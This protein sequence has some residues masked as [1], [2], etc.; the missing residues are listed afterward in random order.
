MRDLVR[1]IVEGYKAL[2]L[3]G[4]SEGYV[5]FRG[6]EPDT[7]QQVWIKILPRL[8]VQ[9][10]EMAQRVAALSQAIRQLNHPNIVAVRKLGEQ[11]GLPYLIT[12]ALEAAQPLAA[13]LNQPWAVDEAADLVM[14]VGRALE[15]AHAKG[16]LHGSLSPENI[17][18][19]NSGRVQVTDFGLAELQELTG[20]RARGTVSPYLAPERQAGAKGDGRSDVY[21]LAAILYGMLAQRNPQIVRGEVLPPGRFNPE[22]PAAM[23]AVVVKALAPNATD[24]YPDVKSFLAAFGAVTLAPMIKQAPP[25]PPGT[26]CLKCGAKGQSGRFCRACGARLGSVPARAPVLSKKSILD[27]PIQQTRVD[28]G[29][30]EVGKGVEVHDTTISAPI[31]VVSSEM[32]SQFPEPLDMPRI[33]AAEMWSSLSTHLVIPMPDPLPMPDTDWA[34]AAPAMP[35]VPTFESMPVQGEGD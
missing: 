33:D 9:N 11:G 13:K 17:V 1:Q 22:V 34:E 14:Q 30:I 20:V 2:K 16:L 4:E 24:R 35:Q 7:R 12:R 5:V 15:H 32:Q 18:V 21:S 8:L 31:T 28:V 26:T 19:E 23:D 10:P 27:E 3:E 25:E 29:R 6:Q